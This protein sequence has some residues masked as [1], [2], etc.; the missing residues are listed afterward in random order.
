MKKLSCSLLILGLFLSQNSFASS[1]SDDNALFEG[2][3]DVF[4]STTQYGTGIIIEDKE[5]EDHIENI[6]DI[7][8]DRSK[9]VLDVFKNT[10]SDD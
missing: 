8:S 2:I 4:K 7:I 6:G 10:F 1:N 9:E 5:D 3:T